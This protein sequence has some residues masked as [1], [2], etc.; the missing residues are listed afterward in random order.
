MG[1]VEIVK[2]SARSLV[3]IPPVLVKKMHIKRGDAFI[4][5]GEGDMIVL[6]RIGEASTSEIEKILKNAHRSVK[7]KNKIEKKGAGKVKKG[8]FWKR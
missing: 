7:Q 4:I 3:A 5:D 1:E 2:V 6:K 8:F